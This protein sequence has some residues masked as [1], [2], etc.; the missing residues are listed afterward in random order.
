MYSFVDFVP[1]EYAE[2]A[3]TVKKYF[4]K[5][6]KRYFNEVYL[7]E[8]EE[9]ERT[10]SPEHEKALKDLEEESE[11]D[12]SSG[13]ESDTS[14]F[15]VS[16]KSKRNQK[17]KAGEKGQPEMDPSV[18]G[19]WPRGMGRGAMGPNGLT[20][21]AGTLENLQRLA[22]QGNYPPRMPP[23]GLPSL[24]P[25]APPHV[26][27]EYYAKLQMMQ[28]RQR[29][30]AEMMRRHHHQ[31]Q[32]QRG[33]YPRYPPGMEGM[34]PAH[35][36]HG[37]PPRP[38]HP[39]AYSNM[40]GPPNYPYPGDH[41][42]R[43]PY[44]QQHPHAYRGHYPPYHNYP[45]N[46]QEH[47]R[48]P[49][50][51]YNEAAK[52]WNKG[53]KGMPPSQGEEDNSVQSPSGRKSR[54]TSVSSDGLGVKSPPANAN[55]V[56]S[57]HSNS[58]MDTQASTVVTTPAAAAQGKDAA[59]GDNVTAGEKDET[60]ASSVDQAAAAAKPPSEAGSTDALTPTTSANQSVNSE[61]VTSTAKQQQQQPDNEA[62]KRGMEAAYKYHQEQMRR[63]Q[64]QHPQQQQQHPQQQQ[65]QHPQQQQQQHP[66]QQQQQHPQQQQ[67]LPPPGYSPGHMT[68]DMNY[69]KKP[70]HQ[71]QQML[72][73]K[74]QESYMQWR[75]HQEAMWR[76]QQMGM[77]TPPPMGSP[78]S[79][80]PPGPMYDNHGYHNMEGAE[81]PEAYKQQQQQ[82][83]DYHQQMQQ[84]QYMMNRR[85]MEDMYRQQQRYGHPGT[86]AGSSP[87]PYGHHHPGYPRPPYHSPMD[88]QNADGNPMQP[89]GSPHLKP[90]ATAPGE[91]IP[92][93]TDSLRKYAIGLTGSS[94]KNAT[95]SIKDKER[96]NS[97][98][99]NKEEE[100]SSSEKDQEKTES[101][102]APEASNGDKDNKTENKKLSGEVE[103]ASA[104]SET[105]P[106]AEEKEDTPAATDD[107]RKEA[108]KSAP[109]D[110]TSPTSSFPAAD[111]TTHDGSTPE[112]ISNP[113]SRPSSQPGVGT[114]QNGH[115]GHYPTSMY[116][117]QNA[118]GGWDG[119]QMQHMGY[120]RGMYPPSPMGRPENMEE[121][122]RYRMYH[123]QQMMAMRQMPPQDP[124]HG[125]GM[126]PG[127][128][129]YEM[130]QYHYSM[131]QGRMGG[132]PPQMGRGGYP[133][134]GEQQQQQQHYHKQHGMSQ[135]EMKRYQMKQQEHHMAMQH[136]MR[137]AYH[138]QQQQHH[139]HGSPYGP[140]SM[141]P[142]PSM[143]PDYPG[144]SS[145][146]SAT[147]ASMAS[148]QHQKMSAPSNQQ[149][150][151]Q[152]QLPMPTMAGTDNAAEFND[153]SQEAS[154][155]NKGEQ[156]PVDIL[157]PINVTT[158]LQAPRS[159]LQ[160][161]PNWI[162]DTFRGLFMHAT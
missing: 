161:K 8:K 66:Q 76:S 28:Q 23:H 30:M 130:E 63:K 86:H 97:V 45:N 106:L 127:M 133:T 53:Y 33:S 151:Q 41:M 114:A 123:E 56:Q 14:E 2:V 129:P 38:N 35:M 80:T 16:K 94:D 148:G 18:A 146:S 20:I 27:Q 78:Y 55:A 60:D 99:S 157:S 31:Q 158:F 49:P 11:S 159:H 92:D 48:M 144:I 44:Q 17:G 73:P 95:N 116:P 9:K 42:M 7:K 155:N 13:S 52:E 4:K 104:D 62:Y 117:P 131:M 118:Y 57:S 112:H 105:K 156:I 32:Q 79:R 43:P 61:A 77:P 83:H 135:E 64:Q 89:T 150:M 65:Q 143:P 138:H 139:H 1:T 154:S 126:P 102:E 21:N 107:K 122:E 153:K 141:G 100:K 54:Q 82:Q 26:Q 59:K 152:K 124:Y 147:A 87:Y 72:T 10:P 74:Q 37:M 113:Q 91:E 134:E 162:A 110:V 120:N 75:Q 98:S 24:P 81:A 93:Y 142:P 140:S 90:D 121:Y 85:Y 108:N 36:Q 39:E 12:D 22:P 160:K 132:G 145:P 19:M 125:M 70:H 69:G 51:D 115:K 128:S 137:T 50:P 68:G 34:P 25:N 6:C 109:T 111:S 47:Y 3:D 101:S 15:G 40:M 96:N 119:M 46:P 103:S 58:P 84:Q 149:A 67:Q 29:Y 136:Q 71:Q 5:L 88:K